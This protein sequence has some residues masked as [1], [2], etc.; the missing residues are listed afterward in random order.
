[1]TWHRYLPFRVTNMQ[2]ADYMIHSNAIQSCKLL[3]SSI[4]ICMQLLC[5]CNGRSRLNFITCEIFCFVL[6]GQF[7]IIWMKMYTHTK[8]NWHFSLWGIFRDESV[9]SVA[10]ASHGVGEVGKRNQVNIKSS[11]SKQACT[12]LPWLGKPE[13]CLSIKKC[14]GKTDQTYAAGGTQEDRL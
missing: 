8:L 9:L 1:M 6:D 12:D 11:M 7:N 13:E 5:K 10:Q 4:S 3:R 2:W 14:I